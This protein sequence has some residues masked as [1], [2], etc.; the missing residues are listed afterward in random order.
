[1]TPRNRA[2]RTHR[3]QQTAAALVA[4][5][6]LVA[7]ASAPPRP[8]I[9]LT[10]PEWQGNAISYSG[11]RQGQSPR[12]GIYPS[13]SEILEDLRILEQRWS[14]IR[15]YAA[16]QHSRDVL[17][18]I[19]R[20][21]IQLKVM[22]GAYFA[23]EPGGEAE[24]LRQIEDC[25]DLANAYPD[26]VV[27]VNVGNEALID[28]SFS[29]VPEERV[30]EYVRRVR[31][32]VSVPVTVAD[33]YVY[34][35]DHG[36]EMAELVDFVTV[37][38]YPI[39]EKKDIDEGLSY[40]VR[41]VDEVRR[42]LPGKTIVI[43]EAGW[44]TYTVGNQHVARA[45][46]EEKQRRYLEELT[47]WGRQEGIPVFW[48][49]AF[50][51]PWKGDGTEGHWGL[52][53][54]HRRPKLAMHEWY[55]ELVTDELTSPAYSAADLPAGPPMRIAFN[56]EFAASVGDGGVNVAA[57]RDDVVTASVSDDAVSGD[58]SLKMSH[59]GADWG[60]VFLFL[61]A[62][63]DASSSDRLMVSL[64]LP[65]AVVDL[66]IKLESLGGR[67][68]GLS[69]CRFAAETLSNGWIDV[70]IPLSK[71]NKPNLSEV[72]IIGFWHPKNAWGEYVAGD[73]LIDNIRFE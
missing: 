52:F 46:D 41:N 32:G 35:R 24:N 44:A 26:V 21:Q 28:W 48:F 14:L 51:E 27:A 59:N 36:G 18:V 58:T 42:A 5:L 38:T 19:R 6:C 43:G 16:D 10:G 7:C 61:D 34:W 29:P 71:F 12:D 23:E 11:Y 55:P 60:G 57:G 17:E 54:V 3:R 65:P 37:H 1:M 67:G 22:L 8:E 53:D 69:L 2:V 72:V 66:E 25:I 68:E 31:E 4:C 63:L 70:S 73:V 47:A 45:G 49:E 40:T 30:R 9:E 56:E 62:P 33:N 20:E 39:W 64:K 13:R 15:T 50:D